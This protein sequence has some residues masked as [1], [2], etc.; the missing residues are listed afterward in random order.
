MATG[1][2]HQILGYNRTIA[3]ITTSKSSYSAIM[4]SE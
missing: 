1:G 2:K 3:E 4:K